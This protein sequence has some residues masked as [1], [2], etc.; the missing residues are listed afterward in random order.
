MSTKEQRNKN[1]HFFLGGYDLEMITIKE[2]LETEKIPYTD[3]GLQWG[4]RLSSYDE[5]MQNISSDVIP[6]LVELE[7]DCQYPERSIVIDHH[8]D[9]QNLP[10]SLEQIAKLLNLELDRYQKLV[11]ANDRE[12]IFGMKKMCATKEEIVEIRQADRNAQGVSQE[13]EQQAE[14]IVNEATGTILF[15]PINHFSAISDRMYLKNKEPYVLYNDRKVLFYGFFKDDV[16]QWLKRQNFLMDDYYFGG[17]DYGYIGLKEGV[18]TAEEIR[19]LAEKSNELILENPYSYHTFMLPFIYEKLEELSSWEYKKFTIDTHEDYNEYVYFYEY[20]R[21]ALYNQDNTPTPKDISQYYEYKD[22]KGTFTIECLAG[23]GKYVLELDGISLR[24]FPNSKVGIVSFN[25]LNKQY[26]HPS[27]ILNINEYGRRIYPQFLSKVGICETKKAFLA[28]SISLTFDG[29]EPITETFSNSLKPSEYSERPF[30][31]YIS[32]LLEGIHQPQNVI[33][34]RMFVMSLYLNDI[35]AE[36]Y[37]SYDKIMDEYCYEQDEWWYKYIFIDAGFKTCQSKHMTK[38]LLAES[39]YDR[40][41]EAGT[42]YGMSRYSFV[43]LTGSW[44]GKNILSPHFKTMYFQM[45]TLLLAYRAS[46]IKFSDDVVKATQKVHAIEP[47]NVYEEYLN[48][49]NEL[50]FREITAQEQGI[51]LYNQAMKIMQIEKY[52]TDLDLEIGELHQYVQFQIE[53][54]RKKA[55][56][57]RKERDESR[58]RSLDNLTRLGTYLL[59]PSLISALM[60][61]N[62]I[63]FEGFDRMFWIGIWFVGT[64]L[65]VISAY[66]VTNEM[67]PRKKTKWYF[68]RQ[69][70]GYTLAGIIVFSFAVLGIYDEMNKQ[71]E[72]PTKDVVINTKEK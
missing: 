49:V 35:L 33:D 60:G 69:I 22:Q 34:D 61:M 50:F 30:P 21:K 38:R 54:A 55:E 42:L 56:E 28:H 41:V 62:I 68:S 64:V 10:S 7:L 1:Y 17:G 25:L 46:I 63:S 53:D 19:N 47:K 37:K 44:Y 18:L 20:V 51:E 66:L 26:F 5:V 12:Y 9:N 8:N 23:R 67:E 72:L 24:L 43:A 11:A 57:E 3:K 14:R 70:W 29:K 36:R 27:D 45:F 32:A 2:I 71:N 15:S 13:E 65:A 31:A 59:P 6:V 52:I 4:A 16:T 39:T 40:W 58:Q 48:F